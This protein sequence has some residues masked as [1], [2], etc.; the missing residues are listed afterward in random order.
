MRWLALSVATG[1][2]LLSY[3]AQAEFFGLMSGRS[4]DL[5]KLPDTSVEFGAVL[6][7][8]GDAD[9]QYFGLRYNYRIDPGMMVYG[10]VGQTEIEDG[11]GLAFGF[12][13]FYVVDG[14]LENT[15]LALKGSFHRLKTEESG[16]SRDDK[17]QGLAIEAVFSGR[18]PF[19][20]KKN[21]NWY[22]N[23][24]MHRI[25]VDFGGSDDSETELG[26]GGGIIVPT[27]S[28]QYFAGIDLIDEMIFG[29]GYRY[30]WQ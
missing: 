20:A 15:D 13:F 2:M 11:D 6:G 30:Y 5:S 12:G 26:F 24:G 29:A 8:L 18:S 21:L 9:Y 25:S 22:A 7:D 4:A 19:G 23:I 10:D 17:Y 28:G 27:D 14:V 16:D 3:S 1:L